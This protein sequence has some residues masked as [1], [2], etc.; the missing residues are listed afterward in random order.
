[1]WMRLGLHSTSSII[2]DTLT[3]RGE[4]KTVAAY[5]SSATKC[6]FFSLMKLT[7]L[8]KVSLLRV[9]PRGFEGLVIINPFT[10]MFSCWAF[11][12][13]ASKASLVIW[14]LFAL[15]HSTGRIFTCVLHLKSRSNL[16]PE[17]QNPVSKTAKTGEIFGLIFT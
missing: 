16:R 3:N 4:L 11:W 9:V 7:K 17:W 14:K 8:V 15:V 1:M 5:I 13:A 2:S 12:Y 6:M 10:L